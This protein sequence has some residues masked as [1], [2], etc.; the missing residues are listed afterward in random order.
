MMKANRFIYEKSNSIVNIDYINGGH[1]LYNSLLHTGELF[2]DRMRFGQL[3]LDY[4]CDRYGIYRCHLRIHND[5]QPS[6]HNGKILGCYHSGSRIIEIW[7]LTAKQK[8]VVSINVFAN[9][10]L[11]EFMHHYDLEYLC[12]CG[13]IHCSGFYKRISELGK[14]LGSM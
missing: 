3:L 1:D 8:K 9:T 10:L 2:S 4:L 14:M 7:N 12:L 11:H 6:K 5:V 13:T